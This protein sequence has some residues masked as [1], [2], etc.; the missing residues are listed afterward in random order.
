MLGDDAEDVQQEVWLAVYQAVAGVVK[1]QAFRTWLYRTTRHRAIDFLRRRRRE[2]ELLDDVAADAVEAA[3]PE[4][5]VPLDTL[6]GALD[7]LPPAHREILLLRYAHDMSYE[8]I[9]LVIGRPVGTV[10]SRLHHAKARAHA[11]L[12]RGES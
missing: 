7:R 5:E 9:A 12:E 11:L 6:R 2:R 3:E 10:R 4:D 8:E 1:P